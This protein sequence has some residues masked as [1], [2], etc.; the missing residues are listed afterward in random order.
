VEPPDSFDIPST[1]LSSTGQIN[2][3]P[4]SHLG[5]MT[6]AHPAVWKRLN[7]QELRQKLMGYGEVLVNDDNKSKSDA[8]TPF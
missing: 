8:K 6:G 5:K 1:L 2:T 3:N 7:P 4:D